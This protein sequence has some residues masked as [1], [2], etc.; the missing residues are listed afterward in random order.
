MISVVI[1]SHNRA[2]SLVRALDSLA[3]VRVPEG[4]SW[5]IC[6]VDNASSDETRQ[7][8]QDFL[9]RHDQLPV[10]Y[11]YE[12]TPGLSYARNTGIAE[13]SGEIV[14]FLDDDV[15]VRDDW[16]VQ[17]QQAF[18][19][20]EP[21]CVGGRAILTSDVPRPSWWHESYEGKVG[22]FDRGDRAIVSQSTG[23]GLIGI[24]A[25]LAFRRDVFERHGLFRGELGRKGKQLSTGEEVDIVDRLRGNGETAAYWPELVV[26]H[27]PDASR[28]TKAY[29]RRW[30]TGFGGWDYVR[31]KSV[32]DD[33]VRILGVPRWRYRMA[34]VDFL[35]LVRGLLTGQPRIATRAEFKLRSFLGYWKAARQVTR[36]TP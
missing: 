34:A 10:Q 11:V 28:F 2:S 35:T 6:V 31:E 36:R 18:L 29:L 24:G 15:S 32:W 25:N 17:L 19:K 7:V 8:V 1:C 3:L 4:R 14:A 22:H 16:L 33:S 5:E 9:E 21:S 30:F 26:Y 23:D 13:T 27:Y 20:L 12:A